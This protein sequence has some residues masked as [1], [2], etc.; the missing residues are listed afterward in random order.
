MT[1]EDVEKAAKPPLS[2]EQDEALDIEAL[3]P[4]AYE[5]LRRVA[6]S[7]FASN[8]RAIT[9]QPTSVVHDAY[10]KLT[11]FERLQF[12]NQ[13]HFFAIA[14]RVMRQVFLDAIRQRKRLKRGGD[15]VRVVLD[16]QT[17]L[18]TERAP[19]LLLLDEALKE[20]EA[21]AP[22]QAT[23]VEL[24]Y[25][26]GLS[27]QETADHLEISSASVVRRWRMARAWL[28]DALEGRG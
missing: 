23:V 18:S 5:H 20:L 6:G 13:T 17:A 15:V 11:S 8:E 27:I 21:V 25:F 9:L 1:D 26:G 24:R 28:F 3:M 10:I 22:Q 4:Q 2:P 19:D 16:E 14:A 12:R 7:L